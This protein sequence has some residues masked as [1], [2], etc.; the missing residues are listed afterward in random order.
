MS[1]AP[2]KTAPPHTMRQSSMLVYNFINIATPTVPAD[3]KYHLERTISQRGDSLQCVVPATKKRVAN[4]TLTCVRHRIWSALLV[5]E[6]RNCRHLVGAGTKLKSGLTDDEAA[7]VVSKFSRCAFWAA[8]KHSQLPTGDVKMWLDGAYVIATVSPPQSFDSLIREEGYDMVLRLFELFWNI[9]KI[10]FDSLSARSSSRE[11]HLWAQVRERRRVAENFEDLLDASRTLANGMK[12][13]AC[14][15]ML[16]LLFSDA[17]VLIRQDSISSELCETP[18]LTVRSFKPIVNLVGISDGDLESDIW[19]YICNMRDHQPKNYVSKGCANHE[20]HNVAR[21]GYS[22]QLPLLVCPYHNYQFTSHDRYIVDDC[23][24]DRQ[25]VGGLLRN[26]K[27]A[28]YTS[29]WYKND[30]LVTFDGQ[31]PLDI[32]H[33]VAAV[34]SEDDLETFA[35]DHMVELL[36]YCCV[37]D[38]HDED[39][40]DAAHDGDDDDD[41]AHDGD[42]DDDAA[43]DG[44]DDDDDD[45]DETVDPEAAKPSQQPPPPPSKTMAWTSPRAEGETQPHGFPASSR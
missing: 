20:R 28:N 37:E 24:R 25:L 14:S 10:V 40:I 5:S 18:A 6:L 4:R 42:D 13:D 7:A 22:T 27:D 3:F 36:I 38:E 17:P 1:T 15:S 34:H 43:H 12:D 33:F 39:D 11:Y 26:Y 29:F 19:D 16:E 23:R 35:R 9:D 8:R 31:T 41:A 32:G 44:D 2:H 21:P 30:T 45:H